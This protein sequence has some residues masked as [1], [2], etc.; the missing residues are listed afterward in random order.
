MRSAG[1]GDFPADLPKARELPDE[2]LVILT[3]PANYNTFD[4][5]DVAAAG[6][7]ELSGL[8]RQAEQHRQIALVALQGTHHHP[9]HNG[10]GLRHLPDF[11]PLSQGDFFTQDLVED[12]LEILTA[13]RATTWVAAFALLERLC[14][15]GLR[16]ADLVWQPDKIVLPVLRIV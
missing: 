3:A 8:L 2:I 6:V 1:H 11:G 5:G 12:G 9:A 14:T 13:L 16:L 4:F 10:L 7:L 15:G